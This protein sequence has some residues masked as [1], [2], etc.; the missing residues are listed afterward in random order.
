MPTRPKPI[1]PNCLGVD[2]PDL[3]EFHFDCK[4]TVSLYG[5]PENFTAVS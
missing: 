3:A 2:R 4:G 1:T 5:L